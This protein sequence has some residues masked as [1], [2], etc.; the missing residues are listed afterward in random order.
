MFPAN[1]PI[2]AI[3]RMPMRP[4]IAGTKFEFNSDS[5][6]LSSNS[7]AGNAIWKSGLHT[8]DMKLHPTTKVRKEENDTQFI[9]GCVTQRRGVEEFRFQRWF[10]HDN[11]PCHINSI[12]CSP[13]GAG[14]P[15]NFR[16]PVVGHEAHQF[17][18]HVADQPRITS[19]PR[20][21]QR[22]TRESRPEAPALSY[23][24]RGTPAR[25]GP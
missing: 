13:P 9:R 18:L 10:C 22:S 4:K 11:I 23:R 2:A 17:K 21:P 24:Q 25:P 8:L 1:D 6:F 12:K 14:F 7:L 3:D 15:I 19:R 5:P 16:R 20:Y